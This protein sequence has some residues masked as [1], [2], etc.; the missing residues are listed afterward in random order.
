MA[1]A[2][3]VVTGLAAWGWLKPE[4]EAPVPMAVR[5]HLELSEEPTSIST[6]MISPDGSHL[7]YVSGTTPTTRKLWVRRID[8]EQ[9]RV[10]YEGDAFWPVFSPD[11][12]WIAFE[13]QN[14]LMKVALSGGAPRIVAPERGQL[15]QPHW[16]DEGS[17]VFS[18]GGR[19]YRV[20]ETGGEPT[21]ITHA[22]D[23]DLTNPHLLPGGRGL[24]ASSGDTYTSY[25]V[26]METD[27]IVPIIPGGIAPKYVET[28]HVLYVDQEGG[29]WAR[30]FDPSSG[31]VGGEATPVL[32]GIGL[33]FDFVAHVSVSNTGTLVYRAGGAFQAAGTPPAELLVV[34][35]DGSEEVA[36]LPPR[37]IR[38]VRW[39][40]D[41]E[42]VAY[43]GTGP[44]DLSAPLMIYEYNVE[45]Q[46]TPTRLTSEGTINYYPAWSPDGTRIAFSSARGASGRHMY[47]KNVFDDSAPER[48]FSEPGGR[49]RPD[50]WLEDNVLIFTRG[51]SAARNNSWTM[52]VPD[53]TSAQAYVAAEGNRNWARVAP[54][55]DLAAYQS[56]ETGRDEIFVRSFPEPRQPMQVSSLGGSRPNWS[57]DGNSIYYWRSYPG[58][59]SLF[60]ARVQREPAFRVLSTEFVLAG[61]YRNVEDWDLHP[62]GDRFVTTRLSEGSSPTNAA[63]G[64][65]DERHVIVTNWFTEL[66]EAV[67]EAN[68]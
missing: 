9:F 48:I 21:R 41:G 25:F 36:P 46:T 13:A 54:Q 40:P 6:I 39:A 10:L 52:Q 19:I 49:A 38:T 43:S 57:P 7:A 27:Q 44:S 17:I 34:G 67:G 18:D 61:D 56:D 28:G 45:L 29:V 3:V 60:A 63:T 22:A 15:R 37:V 24:L 33:A 23:T 42:R 2:I 35:L 47:V 1:A 66:L 68:R 14:T 50:Q 64:T 58:E 32:Q 65:A 20:P 16:G 26:D 11:G 4:P 53:S 8:E 62:E 59:D 5:A 31:E 30:P 51:G 12:D 55:R